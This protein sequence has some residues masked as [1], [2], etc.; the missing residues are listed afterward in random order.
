MLYT[1]YVTASNGDSVNMRAAASKN[2]IILT[3]VPIGAMVDVITENDDWC[4][5]IYNGNTGYMMTEFLSKNKTDNST[6]D[7]YYVRLKCN[8]LELAQQLVQI[9]KEACL[10]D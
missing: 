4:Q 5:I 10:D 8:S 1:A 6:G 7:V 2:A 3:K 9:F